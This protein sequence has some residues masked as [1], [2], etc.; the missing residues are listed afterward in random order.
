MYC[1]LEKGHLLRNKLG[2]DDGQRLEYKPVGRTISATRRTKESGTNKWV[3]Q[4][5]QSRQLVIPFCI[6]HNLNHLCRPTNSSRLDYSSSL[7]NSRKQEASNTC[8]V[9]SVAPR[10]QRIS[11]LARH[12]LSQSIRLSEPPLAHSENTF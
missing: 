10:Y 4:P 8:L 3:S 11:S 6:T 2:L 12:I 7:S 1:S 5:E 9:Q